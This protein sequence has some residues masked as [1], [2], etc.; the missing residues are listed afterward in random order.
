VKPL[1]LCIATSLLALAQPQP[2]FLPAEECSLCH[3][4][5]TPPQNGKWSSEK[6]IGQYPLWSGSMMARASSDPFWQAKVRAESRIAGAAIEDK[7]LSCHAPVQQRAFAAKGRRMQLKNL[8]AGGEGVTCTVCHRIAPEGFG[9]AKSFTG[10]FVLDS[11][12]RL[13]GPHSD[14]FTM[15]MEHHTGFTPT[16]GRHVLEAALCGTCHTV[17]THDIAT[18]KPFVEQAPYLEWLASSYPTAGTTCQSCHE[19]ALATDGGRRLRQYIAHNPGGGVFPPTGPRLPYGLHIFA[20]GNA[21]IP[22]LTPDPDERS[23]Q[24]AAD[25]LAKSATITLHAERAGNTLNLDV[26]L[27]NRTGHKLPT[28]YGSR[29]LWLRVRVTDGKGAPVFES[30]AWQA[31]SGEL[32][33]LPTSPVH[34][35][36]IDNANQVMVW[37]AEYKDA[38]G[39][40]T[41]SLARAAAFLKDNRILPDGFDLS[42]V[43]IDGVD[44]GQLR[45]V[46]TAS[47]PDFVPGSDTVHYRIAAPPHADYDILVEAC[48]Q[49]VKPAH[50]QSIDARFVGE[51][52]IRNEPLVI[53][54]QSL[55]VGD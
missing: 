29:R 21:W 42:R 9:T 49:S 28:G 47:D 34:L 11:N 33:M 19:P 16:E 40:P 25:M 52:L 43:R 46:M 5:I 24:R 14:P 6:S 20:G 53:A 54:R 7:C 39:A 37:E 32:V 3:S 1:V 23:P 26:K 41:Q 12:S 13:F 10:G 38:A 15:P 35:Q 27:F 36:V 45:P 50:L 18:G 30:G 44:I 8:D 2:S 22:A 17:I 4:Q 55:H 31:K 51:L 48:F